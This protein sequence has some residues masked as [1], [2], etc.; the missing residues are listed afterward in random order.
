ME[1]LSPPFS[2][3]GITM[4][5]LMT[6][7]FIAVLS[8]TSAFS[9]DLSTTIGGERK[10]EAETNHLYTDFAVT[11]GALGATLGFNWEDTAE[12]NGEFNF[13][14]AEVDLSYAVNDMITVYVNNDFNDDFKHTETVV[15]GKVK[16]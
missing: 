3:K 9:A 2:M 4:K 7:A 15:G 6:T 10:T 14:S 16:F 13:S 12:D 8:T 1:D 5:L 11:D